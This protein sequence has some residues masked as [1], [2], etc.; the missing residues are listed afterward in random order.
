MMNNASHYTYFDFSLSYI[1]KFILT[2]RKAYFVS[3]RL[4][5]CW[6]RTRIS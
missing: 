5:V 3:V 6:V 4:L 1:W 2:Q